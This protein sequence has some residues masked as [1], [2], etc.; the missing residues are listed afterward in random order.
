[1]EKQ[2]QILEPF[3]RLP[4]ELVKLILECACEPVNLKASSPIP[5]DVSTLL[6]LLL[7]SRATY[8]LLIPRLYR[9]L[10]ISKP[11]QLI[12]FTSTLLHRPA[13]GLLVRNLWVGALDVPLHSLPVIV[14]SHVGYA[15][16]AKNHIE[17]R[18][19]ENKDNGLDV[20][21]SLY[22]E[23]N[24]LGYLENGVEFAAMHVQ[25]M[26]SQTTQ[27]RPPPIRQNGLD[28]WNDLD[29]WSSTSSAPFG[30]FGVDRESAG[31]DAAGERIGMDE[32]M[33]RCIELQ[34]M[35][36]FHWEWIDTTCPK[37]DIMDTKGN[38]EAKAQDPIDWADVRQA[39]PPLPSIWRRDREMSLGSMSASMTADGYPI[40]N[41]LR[42]G[43]DH[44]SRFSLLRQRGYSPRSSARIIIG[45]YLD[46]VPRQDQE[47]IEIDT[48]EFL[49]DSSETD[50]FSH[51]ALFARSG[52]IELI[53]GCEPPEGENAPPN[54]I[55]ASSAVFSAFGSSNYSSDEESDS[56][57]D[58]GD[59]DGGRHINGHAA[60]TM[61]G[62]QRERERNA[63]DFADLYGHVSHDSRT[64]FGGASFEKAKDQEDYMMALDESLPCSPLLP[65]KDKGK[66]KHRSWGKPLPTLGSLLATLRACLSFCPRIRV[67]G[68]NGFLERVVGGTR[69]CVGLSEL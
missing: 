61:E 3:P 35:I 25:S 52:A 32:W 45:A 30:G 51:P 6:S 50:H 27:P 20:D 4:E 57:Q 15:I 55:P 62:R 43:F 54:A 66:Q 8:N 58:G 65:I 37:Q 5:A 44:L 56:E 18:E 19:R 12:A 11:S 2:Q 41:Q 13:L 24:D 21:L 34:N 38:E 64:L 31:Y 1:M 28:Y 7:V 59:H 16:A 23:C 42:L 36:E 48:V 33:L 17:R 26:P 29:A 47:E 22:K 68:L 9:S 63:L 14:S 49:Q 10:T 53:L 69:E 39:P 67:L 60:V 40:A 46:R